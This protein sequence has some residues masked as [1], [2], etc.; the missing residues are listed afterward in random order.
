MCIVCTDKAGS[1]FDEAKQRYIKTSAR[2]HQVHNDYVLILRDIDMHQRQYLDI[3]LP[4]L[5][6]HHEELL[7]VHVQQLWVLLV[8]VGVGVI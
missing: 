1:K 5:L 4:R 3:T 8:R 7:K 2:L 6:D